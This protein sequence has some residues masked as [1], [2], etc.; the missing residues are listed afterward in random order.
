MII[1]NLVITI[2]AVTPFFVLSWAPVSNAPRRV[3][4]AKQI[5]RGQALSNHGSQIPGKRTANAREV[6]DQEALVAMLTSGTF[7]I[8]DLKGIVSGK[9]P[10]NIRFGLQQRTP[11]IYAIDRYNPPVAKILL[12]SG[13]DPNFPDGEKLTPLAHIALSSCDKMDR[14]VTE[15]L[16]AKSADVDAHLEFTAVYGAV[17]N[18]LPFEV[19]RHTTMR[20]VSLVESAIYHHI[21]ADCIGLLIAHGAPVD[22]YA[23][24][25]WKETRQDLKQLQFRR[26][27]F[28]LP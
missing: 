27:L 9:P 26:P 2:L 17:Y 19:W 28:F 13:A 6:K 23:Y 3:R 21:T 5:S 8:A 10:L 7:T 16:L 4:T 25:L 20:K 11:L 24:A 18:T 15:Y 22:R 12:D 1:R 14:E